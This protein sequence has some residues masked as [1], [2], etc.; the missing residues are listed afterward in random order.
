MRGG[1]EPN[2]SGLQQQ[3]A[4]NTPFYPMQNYRGLSAIPNPARLNG[5]D[6]DHT[7]RQFR[8]YVDA[9]GKLT[10][11]I[12]NGMGRGQLRGIINQPGIPIVWLLPNGPF[13]LIPGQTRGDVA[14]FHTRGPAPANIQNMMDNTAGSQPQNPGGPGTVAL[15]KGGSL[16]NPMSG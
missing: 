3:H 2:T 15:G 6:I 13:P 16:I 4:G 14:G 10:M 1:P 11:L 12:G 8:R 7:P 5:E 9:S